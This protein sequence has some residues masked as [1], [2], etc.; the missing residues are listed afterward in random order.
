MLLDLR[1]E[2]MIIL[3][4]FELFWEKFLQMYCDLLHTKI[5]YD[6]AMKGFMES[7]FMEIVKIGEQKNGKPKK[8]LFYINKLKAQQERAYFDFND[9]KLARSLDRDMFAWLEQPEQYVQEFL[10]M[11]KKEAMISLD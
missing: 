9:F 5:K 8:K 2:G 1:G 3:E 6:E 7:I 11:N 4:S 10:N